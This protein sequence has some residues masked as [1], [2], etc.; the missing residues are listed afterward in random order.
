M[1]IHSE[2]KASGSQDNPRG[3][4]GLRL[5]NGFKLFHME[6]QERHKKRI[7]LFKNKKIN[8]TEEYIKYANN[9]CIYNIKYI[10]N[11]K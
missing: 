9:I 6:S 7:N 5:Y 8:V 3:G 10:Y 11:I 4:A 2:L 1:K